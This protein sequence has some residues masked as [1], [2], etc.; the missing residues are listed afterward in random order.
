MHPFFAYINQYFKCSTI[1]NIYGNS[2]QETLRLVV[3][4]DQCLDRLFGGF[5]TEWLAGGDWLKFHNF[6][7]NLLKACKKKNIMLIYYFNGTTPKNYDI[8]KWKDEQERISARTDHLLNAIDFFNKQEMSP[9][10]WVAPINLKDGIRAFVKIM[11]QNMPPYH[12]QTFSS[13]EH[14]P[15]E[16]VQFCKKNKCH[17]ILSDDLQVLAQVY[18]QN[19]QNIHFYSAKSFKLSDSGHLTAKLYD[20]NMILTSL[21]MTHDRFPIFAILL[22]GYNLFNPKWL[23]KFFEIQTHSIDSLVSAALGR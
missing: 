21:H 3:D 7:F 12:M 2:K 1:S 6:Q 20:L 22:D 9:N 13:L 14:H 15:K 4:V 17:G 10:L 18:G 8:D 5:A 19:L 11:R 23:N 16:L